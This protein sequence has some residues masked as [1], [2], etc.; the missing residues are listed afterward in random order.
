MRESVRRANG[1]SRRKLSIL[2]EMLEITKKT[3]NYI[4][5][6][7]VDSL[8]NLIATKQNMIDEIESL[9]RAFLAEFDRIKSETGLESAAGLSRDR[10]PQFAG[11]KETVAEILCVLGKI[12]DADK[13]FNA[14]LINLR[15]SV[16]IDLTRIRAQKKIS[17]LY[18]NSGAS[19][20]GARF[21]G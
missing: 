15:D 11:L 16:S 8:D 6:D 10:S 20:K 19:L 12:A 7:D 21:T 3:T 2:N 14:S 4:C 18:S 5:E 9:D 13:A 17:A 1:I